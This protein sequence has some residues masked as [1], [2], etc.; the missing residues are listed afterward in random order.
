MSERVPKLKLRC[1]VCYSRENDVLLGQQGTALYCLK[2]GFSGNEARVREF[3]RDGRKK[4]L[5][6]NQRLTLEELRAM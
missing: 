4:Y 6:I 2:C 1:P 3:Y 5:L